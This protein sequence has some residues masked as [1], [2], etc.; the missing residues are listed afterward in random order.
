MKNKVK[1]TLMMFALLVGLSVTAA[2][3]SVYR[4][5]GGRTVAV[6][7]N[8]S[9]VVHRNNGRTVYRRPNGRSVVVLPNGRRVVR[10]SRSRQTYP[11]VS[12][13]RTFRLPNGRLVTVLPNGRR[14]YH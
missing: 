4:G 13:A 10:S 6:Y 3:Q 9:R 7:P 5:R 12:R 2:A 1:V 11:Q 8:G 14:I